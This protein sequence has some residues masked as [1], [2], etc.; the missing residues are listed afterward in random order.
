[1]KALRASESAIEKIKAAGGSIEVLKV[2]EKPKEEEKPAPKEGKKAQQQQN[3]KSN[4]P[5][6]KSVQK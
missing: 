2:F 3:K 6:K 1:V 5:A 4:E